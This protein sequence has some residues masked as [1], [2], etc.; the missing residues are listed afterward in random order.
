MRSSKH[1][2]LHVIGRAQALRASTNG[3]EQV[4][5]SLLRG[6][7][8]GVWF[9]R[10]VPLGRFV[11]DFAALDCVAIGIPGRRVHDTRHTFISLARRDGARKDV[12]ERITHNATG[13]IVARYTTFDWAPLC[14]AVACLRLS[15]TE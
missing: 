13:D 5:W 7:Q 6:K 12:L 8:L 1:S 11:A 15:L 2:R 9:R 10:Q 4:L 3:P 14:E